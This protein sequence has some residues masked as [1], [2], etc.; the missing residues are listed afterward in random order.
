MP[1]RGETL[2]RELGK[3]DRIMVSSYE[4]VEPLADAVERPVTYCPPTVDSLAFLPYPDPPERCIDI[5]GMGR[6]SQSTHEAFKALASKRHLFYLY[7]TVHAKA[8]DISEHRALLAQLIMRTKYFV[9]NP[10]KIDQ[11]ELLQGQEEL[12][13]RHF[14]G[15]AGGAVMIGHVPNTPAFAE[16][17]GYEGA[18]F[19]MPYGTEDVAS[20]YDALESTPDAVERIRLRNV[21]QSLLRHDWAYQWRDLLV[22]LGMEPLPQLSARLEQLRTVAASINPAPGVLPVSTPQTG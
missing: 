8:A 5:Y 2:A 22:N 6:R 17:F 1:K 13:A 10:G 3:F 9:A 16:Y 7:D 20:V 11:P 4:C 15:A 18:V 12:A 14:E 21:T 19:H